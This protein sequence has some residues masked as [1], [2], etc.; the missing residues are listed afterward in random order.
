MKLLLVV[1]ALSFV[2]WPV[3]AEPLVDN[4][5]DRWAAEKQ[6]YV[7]KRAREETRKAF[8]SVSE[9]PKKSK[10]GK[11]IGVQG[12]GIEL[13]NARPA[14]NELRGWIE[15]FPIIR[16]IVEPTPPRDYTITVNG[17]DCT[18][19][20]KDAFKV[21]AGVAEVRVERLGKPPC[22]WSGHVTSGRTQE[23]ACNL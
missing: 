8:S 22:V 20:N 23:V 3:L 12:R 9:C 19:H 4:L 13:R 18:S 14:A 10:D 5:I 16:V 21:P 11:C 17:E 7:T 1:F 6:I 2:I 15:K